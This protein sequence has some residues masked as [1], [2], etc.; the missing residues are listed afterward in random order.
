VEVVGHERETQQVPTEPPDRLLES[1][2]QPLVITLGLED[3]SPEV[4]KGHHVMDRTGVFD[5]QW[6]GFGPI[7]PH[8]ARRENR[9]PAP[10]P[11][12]RPYF[13]VFVQR[14]TRRGV[15]AEAFPNLPC[16]I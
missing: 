7:L 9:K 6:S 8:G 14:G 2:E 1:L 13:Q 15:A 3:G 5:P 16:E 12:G 11:R 10:T 4:A